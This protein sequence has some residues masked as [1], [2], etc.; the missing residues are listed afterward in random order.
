MKF[1]YET[2]AT[3]VKDGFGL[4]AVIIMVVTGLGFSMSPPWATASEIEEIRKEQTEM[5]QDLKNTTC[6]ALRIL[7]NDA[8]HDL[9]RSEAELAANPTSAAAL[10]AKRL[11]ETQIAEIEAQ[12]RD[13]KC[14]TIQ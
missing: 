14:R 4:I 13:V 3:F 5:R 9:E 11:A 8:Q 2:I 1:N 6:L 7:L 12:L 10:R